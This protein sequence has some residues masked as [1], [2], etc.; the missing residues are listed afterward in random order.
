MNWA[1][2]AAGVT[3]G[4]GL[5]IAKQW[6]AGLGEGQQREAI[7]GLRGDESASTQG[8]HP[9][10]EGPTQP[11]AAADVQAAPPSA[12]SE[13]PS[14]DKP[15]SDAGVSETVDAEPTAVGSVS[16]SASD[17]EPLPAASPTGTSDGTQIEE[18]L[19]S[20]DLSVMDRVLQ[21]SDDPI[22]RNQLLNRIVAG[23][24][25]L[26][27]EPEHREAFYR[28]AHAQVDE[29]SAILNAY[30]GAGRPR[31]NHIEAFKYITI[32]MG[33]D[34]RYDEAMAICEK[35]LSLGLEDGTKTG[36]KGRIA[37]LKKSRDSG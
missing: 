7:S 36:F 19:A 35:A 10:H 32:A 16:A 34:E 15:D 11:S 24:Y 13:T 30:D 21:E 23:H 6:F 4:L 9:H 25:R 8:A 18:A 12:A 22:H 29:A 5:V 14:E 2:I 26:R 31:P 37:R 33:E 28:L 17:V 27:S 3:A 20:G 1:L